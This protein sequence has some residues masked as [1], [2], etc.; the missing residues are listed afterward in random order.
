MATT[1]SHPS[2]TVGEKPTT[3]DR[4]AFVRRAA[5]LAGATGAAAAA[6][7]AL[8]PA[9][10]AQQVGPQYI[11]LA[12]PYR[13]YDSRDDAEGPIQPTDVYVIDLSGLPAEAIAV[14][15]NLTVVDT[16]GGRGYLAAWGQGREPSGLPMITWSGEGNV[17]SNM[18]TVATG[19]DDNDLNIGCNGGGGTHF[20]VDVHGWY[21]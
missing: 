20:I 7:V 4:R 15:I 8:A 19:T 17:L 13:T 11:P 2:D 12:E 3:T 6:G 18:V 14:T 9:A 5:G 10:G 21:V 16:G 1:P